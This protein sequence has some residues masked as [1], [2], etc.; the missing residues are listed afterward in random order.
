MYNVISVVR[1]HIHTRAHTH[2]HTHEH[3]HI[4]T[5]N[6][7]CTHTHTCTHAQ[8]CI[9]FLKIA[10]LTGKSVCLCVCTC[11]HVCV[12]VCM[13]MCMHACM[14]VCLSVCLSVPLAINPLAHKSQLT[15]LKNACTKI[16]KA[17][18]LAFNACL[19]T[20]CHSIK[21]IRPTGKL[22]IYCYSL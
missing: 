21:T 4:H 3:T 18:K 20:N 5:H 1:V 2:T 8:V 17:R 13:C 19:Y 7:T 14:Y 11:V 22:F 15:G 16:A 9:W 6:H 10:F 12:C